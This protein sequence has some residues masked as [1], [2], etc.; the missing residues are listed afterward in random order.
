VCDKTP[1]ER[2][3]DHGSDR[4][5]TSPRLAAAHGYELNIHG[6]AAAFQVP[7]GQTE[8]VSLL[9][10]EGAG[11]VGCGYQRSIREVA[12]IGWR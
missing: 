1:H 5:I 8:L 4:M 3:S 12:P 2:I 6:L 11:T 10:V 9:V 7:F